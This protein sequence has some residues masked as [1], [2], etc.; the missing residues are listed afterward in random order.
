MEAIGSFHPL[1]KD[2][3]KQLIFGLLIKA[4]IHINDSFSR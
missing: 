4:V 1:Q 2:M 3:R